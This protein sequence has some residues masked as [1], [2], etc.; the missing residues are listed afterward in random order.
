LIDLTIILIAIQ[1]VIDNKILSLPISV[2]SHELPDEGF[3]EL[4]IILYNEL[5]EIKLVSSKLIVDE[6]T[7]HLIY[8]TL[9]LIWI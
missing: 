8:H 9:V 7:N 1:A 5:S 3:N 6:S 4:N 2:F